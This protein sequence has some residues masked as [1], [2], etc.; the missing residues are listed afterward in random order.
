MFYL[1]ID[2]SGHTPEFDLVKHT[3]VNQRYFVLG[4]III[5]E[6]EKKNFETQICSIINY[7]FNGITLPNDFKLH[8]HDLRFRKKNP[9]NYLKN[10]LHVK[11]ADEVF[12]T[13]QSY[14][15]SLI[16][17]QIDLSYMYNR[18]IFPI[19]QRTL[20]L[21]F[22][23][24]RFQYFLDAHN[25]IGKI[26]HEHVNRNENK[27]MQ[28]E[29]GYVYT[30]TNLPRTTDFSRIDPKVKFAKVKIEQNLQYCDF[31]AYSV[32]IRARTQGA[33]QNRWQSI[34]NKYFNLNHASQFLRGN[35]SI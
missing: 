9:Y 15:C 5:H 29:F 10:L 30:T 19:P 3:H 23:A 34:H 27:K 13:I 28:T 14:D 31:F 6:D 22:M 18:Y 4:G 7:Y 25:D 20:A 35:C 1:Y 8:Y 33:A 16:S 32:L 17:C 24:E 12:Q 2:E 21:N 11:L 26:I